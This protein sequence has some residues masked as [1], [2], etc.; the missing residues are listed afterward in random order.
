MRAH[1]L[2]A[3]FSTIAC[4]GLRFGMIGLF[5]AQRICCKVWRGPLLEIGAIAPTYACGCGWTSSQ[6]GH[7]YVITTCGSVLEGRL[8]AIAAAIRRDTSG[9]SRFLHFVCFLFQ[10]AFG[11]GADL[12]AT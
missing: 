6:H 8:A 4:G 5:V 11:A 1:V 2:A 9:M 7:L 10:D 3:P 12:L